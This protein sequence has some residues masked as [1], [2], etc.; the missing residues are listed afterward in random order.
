M[1]TIL[2]HDHQEPTKRAFS[3]TGLYST[4]E[5]AFAALPA[6]VQETTEGENEDGTVE[7]LS[8]EDALEIATNGYA[9]EFELTFS[10]V[11][12]GPSP[13][14]WCY[15]VDDTDIGGDGYAAGPFLSQREASDSAEAHAEWLA[16]R[17][18]WSHGQFD[19]TTWVVAK[20]LSIPGD[21]DTVWFYI[22]QMQEPVAKSKLPGT[23][24]SI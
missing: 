9:D 6:I 19:D 17:L 1:F 15:R 23:P 16:D 12:H 5:A 4:R 24:R 10:I 7:R 11:E 13:T 22:E 14:Y 21:E 3:L 20:D 18:E 8:D 2:I